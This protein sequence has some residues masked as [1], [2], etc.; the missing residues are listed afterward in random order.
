[1][2]VQ[3][4]KVDIILDCDAKRSR[5]LNVSVYNL[6][7]TSIGCDPPALLSQPGLPARLPERR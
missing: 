3:G 1:M 5:P 6:D 4:T 2:V 7:F